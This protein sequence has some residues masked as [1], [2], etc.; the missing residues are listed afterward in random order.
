MALTNRTLRFSMIRCDSA[1]D[2]AC[3]N[4]QILN[5]QL[6]VR[7]LPIVINVIFSELKPIHYTFYHKYV[8]FSYLCSLKRLVE[9]NI[10]G[11]KSHLH[12]KTLA[13]ANSLL[14]T[15]YTLRPKN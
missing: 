8:D 9:K 1:T 7:S 10:I 15:P 14:P 6:L 11:L 3:E 5:S 2:V 4:S 12:L 13:K